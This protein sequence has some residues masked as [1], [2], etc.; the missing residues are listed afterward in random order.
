MQLS[1]NEYRKAVEDN[2]FMAARYK[3]RVA[4]SQQRL[5]KKLKDNNLSDK[6]K[7]ELIGMH[8][9]R[10]RKMKQYEEKAKAKR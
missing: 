4:I 7:E 1:D 9:A 10:I 2:K 5:E 3:R 6:E 8:K